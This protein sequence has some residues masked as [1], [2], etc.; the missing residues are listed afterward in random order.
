MI[1]RQDSVKNA[2]SCTFIPHDE[3]LRRFVAFPAGH[4]GHLVEPQI[5]LR[6]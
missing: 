6:S 4:P 3:Q 5:F 2:L 1:N